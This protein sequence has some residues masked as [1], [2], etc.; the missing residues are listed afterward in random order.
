MPTLSRGARYGP[1]PLDSL[2]D[3]VYYNPDYGV[4][5]KQGVTYYGVPYSQKV[6]NG[7]PERFRSYLDENG[8]YIGPETY[9][10]SD[11]SSAVSIAWQVVDPEIPYLGTY[12]MFP[13]RGNIVA[14]GE[15]QVTSGSHTETIVQ[16][17][18]QAVMYAA[19]AVS[20]RVR[21]PLVQ[22]D[23]RPIPFDFRGRPRKP[24]CLWIEQSWALGIRD[25][26]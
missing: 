4:M 7:T 14:V 9:I 22:S 15:Y 25:P 3:L 24:I 13:G 16:D 23:R 1:D 5:F 17:N 12:F 11:C 18:G 6:R 8:Y 10:G 2:V 21:G 19:Y 20:N 26:K